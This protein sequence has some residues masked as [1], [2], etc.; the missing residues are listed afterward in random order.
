MY[1]SKIIPV[2]NSNFKYTINDGR[3]GFVKH[4][5][6]YASYLFKVI[7]DIPW[8]TYTFEGTLPLLH[9][10]GG[11]LV[12][13]DKECTASTKELA[14][15]YFFGG[16]VYEIL[17]KYYKSNLHKFVDP[18]G[19][20]DVMIYLPQ[21]KLHTRDESNYLKYYFTNIS[22][23]P[24]ELIPNAFVKDFTYW[25]FDRFVEGIYSIP[26][27]DFNIIFEGTEPFNYTINSEGTFATK[28]VRRGNIWILYI[29]IYE[30]ELIK[31]QLLA[32]F[33]D[34]ESDHIVELI[35]PIY[36][37]ADDRFGR[38][39]EKL[40][41]DRQLINDIPIESFV[42]LYFGNLGAIET[43]KEFFNKVNRHK[44]YNH[45]GRLMY[46]NELLPRI[47]QPPHE[48][49]KVAG[50][51]QIINYHSL[52]LKFQYVCLLLLRAYSEGKLLEFCPPH[53][54]PCKEHELI[55]QIVGNLIPMMYEP[56]L[57]EQI[58]RQKIGSESL[59]AQQIIDR[60]MS[61]RNRNSNAGD[62]A[63]E[64]ASGNAAAGSGSGGKVVA[65]APAAAGAGAAEGGSRRKR[66]HYSKRSK[67]I[68]R[69]K[70]RRTRRH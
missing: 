67:I 64:G 12:F 59:G 3:K 70:T 32:K 6:P 21:L 34:T 53:L 65:A 61:I 2:K 60:L 9:S 26:E 7:M 22:D 57:Y 28:K 18:T 51:I 46:L 14:P 50:K 27:D 20:I 15:F 43:R 8:H 29:P 19:D 44:F 58:G 23:N 55:H 30:R 4:L 10:R 63:R 56:R 42:S 25:V 33:P 45:V 68:R 31:I 37:E 35:L 66:R 69:R 17:D 54:A 40:K 36:K 13:T 41:Y 49:E 24:N 47:V 62:S 48:K 16:Y 39:D 11:E 38:E 1:R 52:V 5:F